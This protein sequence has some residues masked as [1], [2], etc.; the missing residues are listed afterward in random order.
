MDV[1]R[2]RSA[3]QA[4]RERLLVVARSVRVDVRGLDDRQVTRGEPCRTGAPQARAEALSA[5]DADAEARPADRAV[6]NLAAVGEQQHRGAGSLRAGRL[7]RRDVVDARRRERTLLARAREEQRG[8]EP[9]G[10]RIGRPTRQAQQ[11]LTEH[12]A[13]AAE[14]AGAVSAHTRRRRVEAHMTARGASGAVGARRGSHEG[15][16]QRRGEQRDARQ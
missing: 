15:Q 9:R 8:H 10:R 3:R 5:R 11:P 6:P 13:P 7:R 16:D 14:G 2:G 1:R 4:R 12:V